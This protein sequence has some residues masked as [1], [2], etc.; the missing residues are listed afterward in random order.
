MVLVCAWSCNPYTLARTSSRYNVGTSYPP[1]RC[2]QELAEDNGHDRGRLVQRRRKALGS[3]KKKSTKRVFLGPGE[4]VPR[5]GMVV[6]K[7]LPSLD[8][9]FSS[10]FKGMEPDMLGNFAVTS[11]T[12]LGKK[13]PYTTL[14]Q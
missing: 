13:Q 5:K 2:C 6:E 9:L 10:G 14:L 11:G 3:G 1:S 8:S 4:G 7:F 12:L